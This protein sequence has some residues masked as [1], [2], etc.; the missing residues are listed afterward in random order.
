MIHQVVARPSTTAAHAIARLNVRRRTPQRSLPPCGGGTGTG[1]DTNSA[2]PARR[3]VSYSSTCTTAYSPSLQ[4]LS[5][6][7]RVVEHKTLSALAAT[8][9]PVPPPQGGRERWGTDLR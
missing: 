2:S 8:P 5:M 1:V 9:L 6:R 7:E 4:S 3:P